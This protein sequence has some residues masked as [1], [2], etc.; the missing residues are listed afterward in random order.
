MQDVTVN[1]SYVTDEARA[2]GE[3]L[4][5]L[6]QDAYKGN[7]TFFA[8]RETADEV[9]KN[10]PYFRITGFEKSYPTR[11]I[12]DVTEN[13]EVYAVERSEGEYYVLSS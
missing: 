6:L 11:L 1:V 7:A 2:E 4:Q 12:I 9:M 13:A 3:T 10:Y 8:K 5:M